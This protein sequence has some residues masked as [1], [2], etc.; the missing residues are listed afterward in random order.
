MNVSRSG[1]NMTSCLEGA[2]VHLRWESSVTEAA[3]PWT[4]RKWYEKVRPRRY[5]RRRGFPYPY[6]NVAFSSDT[7]QVMLY[8]VGAKP[9][10][11][12]RFYASY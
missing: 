4:Q 5:C 7:E 1:V 11:F 6:H 12:Y 2:V 8:L 9:R 10:Q 3:P